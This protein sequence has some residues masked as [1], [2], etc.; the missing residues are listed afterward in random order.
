LRQSLNYSAMLI[1][2]N[3]IATIAAMRKGA[4]NV[5]KMENDKA[6]INQAWLN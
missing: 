1:A 5:R 3:R 2:F 6:N 4:I